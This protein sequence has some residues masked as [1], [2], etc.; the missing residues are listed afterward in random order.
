MSSLDAYRAKRDFDLTAE[1]GADIADAATERPAFVV[2]KHDATR[3][4]YDFRLEHGGVLWS[5]AVTK[6]PSADPSE[7]RLAVRT[8]DHP[9]A[10]GDFEG[11]IPKGQYG[12]GTVMLWDQGWWEPVGD[13]EAGLAKGKLKFRLHGARMSGGWTL[14]RMRGRG[15]E[16]REN[17]LLIKERDDA[18]GRTPD[19]LTNKYK[20][21]VTTGRT[22]RRIA[23][24][25]ETAKP[26]GHAKPTPPFRKVQLAS[27]RDAPPEGGEWRHEAKFDGYRC[28]IAIGKD[29][30][31]LYTRNGKDWTDRFGDLAA[32]ADALA[33]DAA[34]IDGEV[35]AGQGGGD[36]SALQKAL[37][38]GAPL[39]F[40]AFDLLHLDGTD[41]TGEPLTARR[42][43]LEGLL[44]DVPPR[45][46]LRLSPF[47]EGAGD[48][49]LAA[50][51][52]GGG[53]GI[54][55]KLA[56]A[57]YR[58][59]RGTAWIKSKCIRRAEFVIVGW[60]PS[61]KRG[62]PF[63][64]L[65]LASQEDGALTYR[66]RVGTGFDAAAFEEL[67]RAL[68]P[69]ARKTPPLPKPLPPETKGAR[70]VTPKLVAEVAY[71]EFTDDGAV[72]HGVFQGLREDK[73]AEDVSAGAEAAQARPAKGEATVA[74]VRI[75]SADRVVFPKAKLTKG[76]IA[77][78]YAEV[79]D[80]FLSHAA[81][82]PV[83]LLR[84]PGGIDGECFFQK[85]AGKGFPDAVK[86]V[87]IEESDGE[88][89][90][91]M[92]LDS[93]EGI[94]GAVQMG[95]IE[96][97]IWGS[98][99]DRLER[100]DRLVFDLD[101]DEG[102]AFAEVKAA[103]VEVRDALAGL[104]LESGAMVTG[105]KG[106]HVIVPL[107]RVAGW[108]TV[109]TFS[110][111]VATILAQQQPDRYVATMSKAKRKGR[112]FVDWLRNDRGATAIA[113]YSLRA[114]PGAG[115]A[116][117]VTWD[118]L[119]DLER[120]DGFAPADMA[121]RFAAPCPLAAVPTSSITTKVVDALGDWAGG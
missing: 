99:R 73:A 6:G 106:V 24:G 118:E 113:P 21:S 60:A 57:A 90:D 35:I 119:A 8:E 62:R 86:P 48:E 82:H 38:S 117:P 96:F 72:R 120:A 17:W 31:R 11:T 27:L 37:K 9:V 81:D 71:A 13:P 92:Y 12:G 14:V 100:P 65:L 75:S 29:G 70:W 93:A 83:S 22:M 20:T 111:T 85:H 42:A 74:G 67:A 55:S 116:V 104:G 3:L 76:G 112:I 63:S 64:S 43:A 18:A 28:L 95:T 49:V 102:L 32:P 50:I 58:A 109:K 54:V 110:Q 66:G 45:G 5:W 56:D 77:E 68:K 19:A 52:E 53:E 7:K 26:A 115:V 2:Q 46:P 101:P 98:R 108:E 25:A 30:V 1:P 107:R 33:C 39:T 10:Y 41:L 97:H 59:G 40:Y 34:L 84:C 69:L 4:H 15:N 51:C 78:H 61:D 88:I 121:A 91:Y 47:I 114:R 87:P 89:E 79:A 36:F 44:A 23:A 16:T 103:A 80:R 105:G 94:L